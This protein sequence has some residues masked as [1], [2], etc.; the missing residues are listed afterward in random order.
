M[1]RSE[2]QESFV[3][4]GAVNDSVRTFT[5]ACEDRPMNTEI[6][7]TCI[8]IFAFSIVQDFLRALWRVF[9]EH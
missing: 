8:A 1:S 4:I 6:I 2:I 3:F 7:I 9:R 5:R